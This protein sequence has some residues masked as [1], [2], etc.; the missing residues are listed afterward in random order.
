MTG[1][2]LLIGT[3]DG[4]RRITPEEAVLRIGRDPLCGS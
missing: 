1:A 2:A 3:Q 4:E